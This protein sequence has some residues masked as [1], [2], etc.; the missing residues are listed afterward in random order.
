MYKKIATNT[1]AQILSKIIT[2]FISIFLIWILTKYLSLELYGSYNKVYNYLWIFAFLA[3]LGLYAIMIR[4]ISLWKISA[5]KIVW[6]VLTLRTLLWMCAICIALVCAMFIPGLWDSL[7]LSAIAIVW[8]FTLISLINSALLALMQSQ[9]KMEFSLISVVAGKLLNISLVALFLIFVFSWIEQNDIAFISV[10]I[11]WLLWVSL[12]TLLNYLYARKIVRIRYLFDWDYIK[13]I[14]YISFPYGLALFLSVVYF[15]IDIFLIPFF[16]LPGQADISIWLYALPMKIVE[17]LMVL[18]WF[19][20]NSLLPTLTEKFQKN[21]K[22]DISHILGVSIKLLLSFWILVFTLGNLFAVETIRI[23]SR[24]EFINPS[25][26]VYSSV[27]A[28]SLVLW[29]LV[30]H[31]VA[32]VFIY[33]LIAEWKQKLLLIINTCVVLVNIIW[34]ILLIPYYSF[35][36]AAIVTLISQALLMCVSGFI[37]CR[38]IKIPYAY[39]LHYIFSFVYAGFLFYIFSR[40]LTHITLWDIWKI[41]LVSPIFMMLYIWGEYLIFKKGFLKN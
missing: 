12:N 31:F 4:E 25:W 29:V 32:L 1:I 6:N 14:F 21:L 19:Y 9:M 38:S 30:F 23:I 26:H 36:G 15:K 37:V 2:A 18:W 35:I 11:A 22:K 40:F 39:I 16:E 34:N 41:L 10:F 17:V 33:T 3:D 13:H 7:I 27:D 8:V 28:V 24:P 5:E 20:L